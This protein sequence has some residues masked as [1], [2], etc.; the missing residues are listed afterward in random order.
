[1]L[2]KVLN[3]VAKRN[4]ARRILQRVSLSQVAQ[5]RALIKMM[6][7]RQV[8]LAPRKT[9]PLVTRV[10]QTLQVQVPRNNP[11]NIIITVVQ[12]RPLQ[13]VAQK[14]AQSLLQVQLSHLYQQLNNRLIMAMT[15]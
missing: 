14:A 13:R 3:Q 8:L 6:L 4:Q 5:V 11:Q 1:M 10:T 7:P 9:T 2:T 12:T 15:S